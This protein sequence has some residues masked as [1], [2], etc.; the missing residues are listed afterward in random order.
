MSATKLDVTILFSGREVFDTTEVPFASTEQQRTLNM[1]ASSL[2]T[3][4]GATTTP[5]TDKS[6][7]SQK[8]TLGGSPTTLDL[9]AIAGTAIPSA[10]TRML[11]MT[12][13]KLVAIQLTAPATNFA[14]VNVAP[15]G[16][17]P[18]PPFGAGND[19]DVAPGETI[20][21]AVAGIASSKPAVSGTVKNITISGTSGD[22]LNVDMYFGT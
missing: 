11:D 8:I 12:G 7:I 15:G 22:V 17:N 13:A 14:A 2:S 4:Y 1:G 9:T 6:P 10:A 16:A 18:Y 19:I 5:K 21:S 20:G 3:S